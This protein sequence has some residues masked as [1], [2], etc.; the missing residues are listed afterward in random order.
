MLNMSQIKLIKLMMSPVRKSRSRYLGS[1]FLTDIPYQCIALIGLRKD[2]PEDPSE[3]TGQDPEWIRIAARAGGQG[4]DIRIDLLSK[5]DFPGIGDSISIARRIRLPS[6]TDNDFC[7]EPG[8]KRLAGKW[9]RALPR[10]SHRCAASSS[11]F[12]NI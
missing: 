6:I 2:H 7:F 10:R 9:H 5:A 11:I 1:Y 12:R 3:F 4:C 8:R